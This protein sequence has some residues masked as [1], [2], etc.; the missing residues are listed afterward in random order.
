MAP[1]IRELA[2]RPPRGAQGYH[3]NDN[4]HDGNDNDNRTFPSC[5]E[6]DIFTLP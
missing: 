5:S 2:R 4:D 1:S 6:P 3:L